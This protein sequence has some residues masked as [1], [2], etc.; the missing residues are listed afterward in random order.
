MATKL[1]LLMIVA[2]ILTSCKNEAQKPHNLVEGYNIK[3]STSAPG[4]ALKIISWDSTVLEECKGVEDIRSGRKINSQSLFNIGSISKTFVAFGILNLAFE[5]KL[6]LTDSIIK[7]FPDF[8]NK[9]IGKKVKIYHLLTHSSGLPDNRHPHRDSV[10]YLTADDVQN[11]APLLTNDSLEF[12][13][14]SRFNYSNPAFNALA[15][16]IQ[17]VTGLKW[18]DYIKIK[19][20]SIS[21]MKLSTI[22]DGPHPSSGVSHAYL[23]I[24][25]TWTERDFG[26][27]PT[28]NAAGNG[29]VWSSVDEMYLYE[30]AIRN[31]SFADAE[32]NLLSRTIYPLPNWTDSIPSRLGLSWFISKFNGHTMYSHTGS[33]GG[34]T[35][36]FVS[37]PEEGFFY[38]IL[39]NVPLEIMNTRE[40]VLEHAL[41]RGWIRKK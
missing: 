9:E 7:F 33:Q 4:Y 12:E 11:W 37:I 40:K 8:K 36:D 1:M 41:G 24:G 5:H 26:E 27:E 35:S 13:P 21:G 15:L 23:P 3:N 29:G 10:F 25:N 17:Q 32:V 19:I 38:C 28:F 30:K 2:L 18:Q 22:T 31:N 34:F 16:I 6:S 39:S 14:G 20:F